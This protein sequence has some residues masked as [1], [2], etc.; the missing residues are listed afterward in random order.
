MHAP[1]SRFN[2]IGTAMGV[3]FRD[4]KNSVGYG[5]YSFIYKFIIL[6]DGYVYIHMNMDIYEHINVYLY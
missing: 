2:N 4:G 3:W 6:N 5:Y 1:F